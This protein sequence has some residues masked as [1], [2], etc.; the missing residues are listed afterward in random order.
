MNLGI[1]N[2]KLLTEKKKFKTME[3]TTIIT[4]EARVNVPESEA[5]ALWTSTE[6]LSIGTQQAMIGTL[7]KPQM[8]YKLAGGLPRRWRQSNKMNSS[9]IVKTWIE[10]TK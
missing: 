5:W 6:P 1:L 4:V 7:P 8:T 10:A 9:N 3:N 2:L